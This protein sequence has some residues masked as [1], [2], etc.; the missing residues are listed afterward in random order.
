MNN[1][2]T[3]ILHGYLVPYAFLGL[4]FK[5]ANKLLTAK[6]IKKELNTSMKEVQVGRIL[7]SNPAHLG[8]VVISSSIVPLLKTKFPNSVIYFLVG[9]WSRKVAESISG[10]DEIL[11]YR[12]WKLNRDSIPRWRKFLIY[13][14]DCKILL[15]QLRNKEIDLAIDLYPYYPNSSLLLFFGKVKSRLG[16]TTGGFEFLY[17]KAVPFV[18]KDQHVVTSYISLLKEIGINNVQGSELKPSLSLTYPPQEKIPSDEPTVII[19]PGS[20]DEKKLWPLEKWID[21]IISLADAIPGLKIIL[22]GSSPQEQHIASELLKYAKNVENLAGKQS[23]KE[24]CFTVS[25]ANLLIGVD[26]VAGHVASAYSV[27][28]VIVAAGMSN[29]NHWKP[30]GETVEVLTMVLP[31]AP[32][33]NGKGCVE[34][35]CI[36][37]ISVQNVLN[38]VQSILAK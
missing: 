14:A 37:D 4:L 3:P 23:W 18:I 31:C 10:V 11:C 1:K 20:G 7:I 21:L 32:C 17:T 30:I 33:Y 9:N 2:K 5:L 35:K 8:D 12:H 36:R 25:Q 19:H 26:S 13:L 22:T 29:V 6:L 16:F 38:K 27:P 28:V 24:F 34:M 15:S